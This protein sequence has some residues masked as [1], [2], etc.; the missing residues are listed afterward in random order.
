[1][2]DFGRIHHCLDQSLWQPFLFAIQR[3]QPAYGCYPFF[4][5]GGK[6]IIDIVAPA[7][8]TD[9]IFAVIFRIF[10][11]DFAVTVFAAEFTHAYY[12]LPSWG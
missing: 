9:K 6:K 1:M 5:S 2:F 10:K 12:L 11:P 7:K 3:F 4:N 8:I